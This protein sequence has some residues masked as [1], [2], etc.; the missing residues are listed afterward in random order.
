MKHFNTIIGQISEVPTGV[1]EALHNYIFLGDPDPNK[2]IADEYI[3][4]VMDLAAG[5]PMDQSF[6]I[7][8]RESN[9]RGGLGIGS[10]KF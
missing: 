10:T 5:Q 2:K 6:F 1:R 9:S 4:F 3:K 8:K 7:D